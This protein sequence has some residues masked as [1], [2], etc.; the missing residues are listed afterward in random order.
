MRG[1]FAVAF[2]SVELWGKRYGSRNAPPSAQRSRHRLHDDG[3]SVDSVRN[4]MAQKGDG[5]SL[6]F[7]AGGGER[8]LERIDLGLERDDLGLERDDV[9]VQ[10]VALDLEPVDGVA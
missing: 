1:N 9:D 4:Q 5:F 10:R 3:R 8:L 7:L 6:D 2:G